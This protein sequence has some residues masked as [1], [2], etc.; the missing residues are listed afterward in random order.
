MTDDEF[1]LR[2]LFFLLSALCVACAATA[3]GLTVGLLSMD[4]LKLK[5]KAIIGDENEK[6]AAKR[7]MPLLQQHHLLLCTLLL[8][9]ALANESLPLV[10]DQ[11]VPSWVAV[12]LSVTL[13]L[14]VGEV[15][16]SA[17]FTGPR[18]LEIAARFCMLVKFLE[19]LFFPIAYPMAKALDYIMGV[20]KEGEAF[21]RDEL[22]AMFTIIQNERKSAEDSAK[23]H[24]DHQREQVINTANPMQ[25]SCS[26]DS[27]ASC[28]TSF[29][30]G[31]S[32]W[33]SRKADDSPKYAPLSHH[34]LP[35][36]VEQKGMHVFLETNAPGIEAREQHLGTELS[37]TDRE[38]RAISGL[39]GLAKV[40]IENVCIPMSK[41]TMLS[42]E[43]IL[44]AEL[45]GLIEDA[46]HSRLPIF[47]G[48]VESH[49]IGFLLVKKLIRVNPDKCTPVSAIPMH[50][51]LVVGAR[52][53]L[54]DVMTA[55]QTS[56]TH[57]ALVSNFPEQLKESICAGIPPGE[58][59]APIGIL[60]IKDVYKAMLQVD[61][62]DEKDVDIETR[63]R[64]S[65][66]L[67]RLCHCHDTGHGIK[68]SDTVDTMGMSSTESLGAQSLSTAS[69][70]RGAGSTCE[71]SSV[72]LKD[73][74]L[75][76]FPEGDSVRNALLHLSHS[77]M[78]DNEGRTDGDVLSNLFEPRT[79]PRSYVSNNIEEFDCYSS[80][81]LT[82]SK[83]DPQRDSKSDEASG[84]VEEQKLQLP[85]SDSIGRAHQPIEHIGIPSVVISNTE[86]DPMT[87][88]LSAGLSDVAVSS[89][90][91][92]G[93]VLTPSL[94]TKTLYRAGSMRLTRNKSFEDEK[95]GLHGRES[96]TRHKYVTDLK[97][98]EEGRKSSGRKWKGLI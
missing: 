92:S 72:P 57:L 50:M 58:D 21:N 61:F 95:S 81:E 26:S 35:I 8:F 39:L 91:A 67:K 18:Q 34:D 9:N 27:D 29:L 14:I 82:Q 75:L 53:S 55:F 3:A 46:G 4:M 44:D 2:I 98:L 86:M 73:H 51:P 88:S 31:L 10:L 45:M 36:D 38:I 79:G 30:G 48:C 16:P 54:L 94:V 89:A 84:L 78:D 59:V 22:A 20:E 33:R 11:L 49:V 24:D 19:I 96:A 64:A 15:L 7:I 17:L 71:G 1:T 47:K 68:S 6:R 52:Q 63:L 77:E 28:T 5:I 32:S 60:T 37:L 66:S 56:S 41:V 65:N 43:Q 70:E 97:K 42:S 93:K 90:A 23:S 13:V 83:V 69:S 25:S 40:R 80:V 74:D 62:K 76:T 87:T 12:L 85:G